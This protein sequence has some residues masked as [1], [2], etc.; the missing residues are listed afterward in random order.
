MG[1]GTIGEG[2]VVRNGHIVGLDWAYSDR[3]P[4]PLIY[5]ELKSKSGLTYLLELKPDPT[6]WIPKIVSIDNK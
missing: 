1:R 2:N 5:F 4:N 3:D 6:Y